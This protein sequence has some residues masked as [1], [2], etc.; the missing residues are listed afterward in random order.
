[1]QLAREQAQKE[2]AQGTQTD[3]A[4]TTP[5]PTPA[6]GLSHTETPAISSV[7]SSISPTV[8]GVASSPVP[9]TPFVS[10]SN[11]P[12]VVASGSLTNTGTPIALTTSVPGTVSSQSVAAAGGTGPPA[13]L[14]A[15]ASSVYALV[16]LI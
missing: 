15:N 2:A 6:V 7:N 8:S 5:Q 13:V 14:H 9:V 4:A 16:L 12:S 1:M 11:S 10:V 3:I